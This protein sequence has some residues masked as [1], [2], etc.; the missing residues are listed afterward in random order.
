MNG[1]DL[2]GIPPHVN[3]L[4][5]VVIGIVTNNKDPENL[6]RVKLKFP[7]LSEEEE[8]PWA[9]ISTAMAGKEMG[10]YFLPEVDDEVLVAFAHGQVAFPYVIGSLWNGKQRPPTH[11]EDGKNNQRSITSRSGHTVILDDTKGEEKIV[12]QDTTGQNSIIID[13]KTDTMTIVANQDIKIEAQ[14]NINLKSIQGDVTIEC[15]NFTV[16]ANQN[17]EIKANSQ[18][19]LESN[20]GINITCMAGVNLNN[21]ALEVT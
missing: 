15:K 17:S 7:W 16:K 5:G 13:S 11:N 3:Q 1:M 4:Y 14:G 20:S 21:G 18:A 12:V 8:S 6:G 9:R 10:C 19:K 2:S